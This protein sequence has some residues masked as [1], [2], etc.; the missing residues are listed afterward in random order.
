[1][2]LHKTTIVQALT[3]Y[4]G[5]YITGPDGRGTYYGGHCEGVFKDAQ[6]MLWLKIRCREF[7]DGIGL[8]VYLRQALCT[9]K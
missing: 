8:L 9:V 7:V 3:R 1:M 5:K 4:R 6:G 2:K